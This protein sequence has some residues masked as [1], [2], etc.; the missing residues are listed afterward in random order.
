MANTAF[1]H[2]ATLTTPGSTT[3]T[4][5][6]RWANTSG[7]SLNNTINILSDGSNI[8]L[9]ARGEVRFSDADS[10]H[11]I[12]FESPA[13]VGTSYT[14]TLPSDLPAADEVLTVTSYSGGAGV[15]EWAAAAGGTAVTG[16]TDN[17]ILTFVNSG[18]T[19]AAEANLRFDG[20]DLTLK[21]TG[22]LHFGNDTDTYIF[23]LADDQL[24]TYVGNRHLFQMRG[25]GV[26]FGSAAGT[27]TTG[28]FA[29]GAALP[30]AP[31]GGSYEEGV[32]IHQGT[33]GYS[34]LTFS[35]SDVGHG[36]TD[37]FD[38]ATFGD[39]RRHHTTGGM[40]VRGVA[41][42][43]H[44]AIRIHGTAGSSPNSASTASG[45][46]AVHV[47]GRKKSGSGTTSLADGENIFGVDNN[48]NARFLIKG[49]GDMYGDTSFS[50][51]GDEYDDSQLIR[52]LDIVKD[53]Y[54][55][56]GYIQDKWDNFIQYNE[57]SLID[58]GILGDTLANRGLLNYTGLQKFHSGAIWQLYSKMKDQEEKI[59]LLENKLM[60]LDSGDMV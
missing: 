41:G 11:Y 56:K 10:T 18:S 20:T 47:L 19:F 57:Q 9:N 34:I 31:S 37:D 50:G 16:T 36:T 17:G 21:S 46:G 7:T 23:Q 12:A 55:V 48:T 3:D 60:A 14:M 25:G 24:S 15:L 35:S 44:P 51:I 22:K 43:A 6:V 39:F 5:L 53:G 26:F 1:G 52:A 42:V 54:G 38:T 28:T 29:G 58:A 32:H 59:A 27:N 45:W 2:D 4:A 8:T 13:T 33:T 30:T 40:D 49:N